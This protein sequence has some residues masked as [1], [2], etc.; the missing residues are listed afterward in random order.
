LIPV[1]TAF[2]SAAPAG[3]ILGWKCVYTSSNAQKSF[4]DDVYAGPYQ[5]DREPPQLISAT[6]AGTSALEV[7]WNEPLDT[8]TALDP[9]RYWMT[10]FGVPDS[11]NSLAQDGRRFILHLS[12]PV[13]DTISYLLQI[14]GIQDESGNAISDTLNWP[15]YKVFSV[16][17]GQVV[18]TEIMANPSGAPSLPQYEYVELYNRSAM[19]LLPARLRATLSSRASMWFIRVTRQR[20]LFHQR[21]T[22]AAPGSV[23]FLP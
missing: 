11:I 23:V 15:V 2:H 1:G 3:T 17:P 6:I 5:H 16:E 13:V 14:S 10:P 12:G 8:L 18:F 9:F 19:H 7:L 4:L 22:V 21:D 20:R